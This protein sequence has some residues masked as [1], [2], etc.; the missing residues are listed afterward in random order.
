MI[1]PAIAALIEKLP[2]P[3]ST[4]PLVDRLLWLHEMGNALNLMYRSIDNI[5]IVTKPTVGQV[6]QE[7]VDKV[8]K[9]DSS[10]RP[11]DAPSN[12]SMALEAI[13]Q[14][15]GLRASARQ[16]QEYVRKKWWPGIPKTWNGCLWNFV[17][18][19]RLARDGIN[20]CRPKPVEAAAVTPSEPKMDVAFP[21]VRKPDP[22]R[23]DKPVPPAPPKR[24]AD[25]VRF[26]HD[27]RS[28]DLPARGYIY[29]M[30]LKAVF[31]QP[32]GE[33]FLADKVIGSNTADNRSRVVTTCLAMNPSL[34]EIGLKIGHYPGFGLIMER[35]ESA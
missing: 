32:I 16:I 35:I 4:W 3:G 6:D 20:F 27:E 30:K 10:K 22:A 25:T 9:I 11:A 5:P 26:E 14:S 2:A 24:A 1:D 12:I 29:A 18:D 34:A 17:S 15:E 8:M 13:D 21:P 31:G 23:L 33:G 7:T 19:G 28:V